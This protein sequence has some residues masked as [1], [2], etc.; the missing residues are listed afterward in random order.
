MHL[1]LVQETFEQREGL[2][3]VT[4]PRVPVGASWEQAGRAKSGYRLVV[5]RS[6]DDAAAEAFANRLGEGEEY[7]GR[8][9]DDTEDAALAVRLREPYPD[10]EQSRSKEDE[11]AAAIR[12]G[13]SADDVARLHREAQVFRNAMTDHT[14]ARTRDHFSAYRSAAKTY[15]D[16]LPSGGGFAAAVV[17]VLLVVAE[18]GGKAA[19]AWAMAESNPLI[20]LAAFSVISSDAFNQADMSSVAGLT[21]G[22]EA[23]GS[24][25]TWQ[26]SGDETGPFIVRST[27]P[28]YMDANGT[29]GIAYDSSQSAVAI[30]RVTVKLIAHGGGHGCFVRYD[31]AADVGYLG[32]FS[33]G[34]IYEKT[35]AGSYSALSSGVG[36]ITAG[37]I[38]GMQSDATT[39][40]NSLKNGSSW[41]TATDATLA[42]GV[43]AVRF[44]S[45]GRVDDWLNE[46]DS[47]AA[48]GQ[49]TARRCALVDPSH[50]RFGRVVE[51]GREGGRIARRVA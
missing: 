43:G 47:G 19:L 24:A 1:F 38:F 31:E 2:G 16:T 27:A 25:N 39:G 50:G 11:L 7:R 26:M 9:I 33:N 3:R 41:A 18:V 49:P 10:F 22:A 44:Y 8:L 46:A 21:M 13:A 35:G 15:E 42:T 5:V 51:F 17:T 20:A 29:T 32:W 6:M 12:A 30:Q 40:L 23:G 37:D 4:V 14:S 45:G 36:T 48:S 28:T 34:E